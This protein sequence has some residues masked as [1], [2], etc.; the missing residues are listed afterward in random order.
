VLLALVLGIP[1]IFLLI[2]RMQA[3][4]AVRDAAEAITAKDPGWTWEEM[5]N[6]RPPVPEGKN[7][8]DRVL[9]TVKLLPPH[10]MHWRHPEVTKK[11]GLSEDDLNALDDL[12]DAVRPWSRLEDKYLTLVRAEVERAGPALAEALKLADTSQG[13]F[14]IAW[15]VDYFETDLEQ[16]YRT[17]ELASL[18]EHA[19]LVRAH[20]GDFRGALAC[21]R[22]ESSVAR[23]LGD[24]PC[25]I[26]YWQRASRVRKALQCFERTLG[27]GRPDVRDFPALTALMETED[28]EAPGLCLAALRGARAG[29]HKMFEEYEQGNVT[30][31]DLM[32]SADMD[33]RWAGAAGPFAVTSVRE[34][35]AAYLHHM[36]AL[37]EA[38]KRPAAEQPEHFQKAL[39]EMKA[40]PKAVFAGRILPAAERLVTARLRCQ[41]QLR[42]ARTGLAAEWYRQ[43][44]GHWPDKLDALVP[45]Y[46]P[47]VPADPFDDQPLR[48]RRTADGVAIY[49]VGP[50]RKDGGG[51]LGRLDPR[52]EG[53][54]VGIRL[55]DEDKRGRKALPE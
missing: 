14:P 3:G 7:G 15:R 12:L 19:A 37:I 1:A 40:D 29:V 48:L 21:V 27:L 32:R 30:L 44:N 28:E 13:R 10:W 26:V 4:R 41:A 51:V 20:D 52:V 6:K 24:E 35:H 5:Q 47:R 55:W 38:A 11:L 18:L 36:T 43:E 2:W 22:A 34:A 33:T 17:T 16:I 49:S 23:T 53:E 50:D 39:Q 31:A 45:K 8:A 25:V 9:A 54:D 46:L 42:S